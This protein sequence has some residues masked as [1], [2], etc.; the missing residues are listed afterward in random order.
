MER[1]K[2]MHHYI[3]ST[4]TQQMKPKLSILTLL[5]GILLSLSFV[6]CG[7]FSQS[8]RMRYRSCQN[9]NSPLFKL[10]Q[11]VNGC[12]GLTLSCCGLMV[13]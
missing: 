8:V 9:L 4:G 11:T 7:F 10:I 5:I 1:N 13:G 6:G 3:N 2:W 12:N